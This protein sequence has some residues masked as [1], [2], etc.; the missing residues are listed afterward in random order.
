MS[1]CSSTNDKTCPSRMNDG[2]TFTD[3]R[4]KCMSNSEFMSDLQ[5]KS[6]V[7]S[8]YESRLYLQHNAEKIMEQQRN[9]A[10][11]KMIC[12]PCARPFTD[13]GTMQPEKYVVRCDTVTCS[14]Q[15]TAPGGLGDGRDYK[16]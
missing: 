5:S 4:P 14:R 1:C 9:A 12:G 16:Y 10:I 8:S 15:E 2:R 6:I 13:P 7:A 3:Y 11:D